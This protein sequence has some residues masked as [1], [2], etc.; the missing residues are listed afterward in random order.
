MSGHSK[1]LLDLY[2]RFYDAEFTAREELGSSLAPFISGLTLLAAGALYLVSSA[3]DGSEHPIVTDVFWFATAIGGL[4]LL[5]GIGF[6]LAALW[7]R[8]YHHAPSLSAIEKWRISNLAYHE[9]H[10]EERPTFDERL[11]SSLCAVVADTASENRRINRHRLNQAHH[12]KLATV[13]ALAALSIS[14]S[15]QAATAPA[16]C[17]GETPQIIITRAPD[18]GR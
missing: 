18:D 6:V 14:A 13:V 4:A 11:T 2:L 5:I 9:A 8:T 3:P 12:A 10:P 7:S 15:I 16:P 17:A 1:E